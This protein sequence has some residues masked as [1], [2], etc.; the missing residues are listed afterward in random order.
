MLFANP[1]PHKGVG[2]FFGPTKKHATL[3]WRA[4]VLGSA[5]LQMKLVR[6]WGQIPIVLTI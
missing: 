2:F 5:W 3:R 6:N 1:A 4:L